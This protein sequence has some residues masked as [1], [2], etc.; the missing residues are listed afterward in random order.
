[1]A[2]NERIISSFSLLY[3]NNGGLK[4]ETFKFKIVNNKNIK[5]QHY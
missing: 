1:M 2:L 3:Q 4:V 5:F